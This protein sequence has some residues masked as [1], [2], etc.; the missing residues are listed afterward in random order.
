[1][2]SIH[3]NIICVFTPLVIFLNVLV[4]CIARFSR[5]N[6]PA[7][8]P[9]LRPILSL[10]LFAHWDSGYR[11]GKWKWTIYTIINYIYGWFHSVSQHH[12]TLYS[13]LTY[14]D[15]AKSIHIGTSKAKAITILFIQQLFYQQL[16][17][18]FI[19]NCAK[20]QAHSSQSFTELLKLFYQS[21]HFSVSVTF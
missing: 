5:Q 3:V 2:D 7:D 9:C 14:S 17:H 20:H 1:M 19:I 15:T 21:R 13:Y 12:K 4:K 16:C 6:Q 10:T 18:Y 11:I 8:S